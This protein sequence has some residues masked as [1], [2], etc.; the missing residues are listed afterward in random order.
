TSFILEINQS[1][2]NYLSSKP[3]LRKIIPDSYRD[4]PDGVII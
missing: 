3:K 2:N 4:Q 1:I